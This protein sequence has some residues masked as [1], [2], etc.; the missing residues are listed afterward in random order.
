MAIKG[1][2][3]ART[4]SDTKAGTPA[5]PID[6]PAKWAGFTAKVVDLLA[7]NST[8]KVTIEA[9]ASH[10]PTKTF[11]TNDKLSNSRMEAARK[12]LLDAVKAAGA[13]PNGLLLESVNHLVQ[14]P[15]YSG[16]FKN[17]EKYGKFQFVKLKV[18]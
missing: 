11:G 17:K 14:G 9:S 10:V 6:A 13:D 18:R 3:Y 16:D 2:V 4:Y 5:F 1:F 8:V 15:K 12:S 7:K